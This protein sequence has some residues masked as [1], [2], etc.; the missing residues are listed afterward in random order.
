MVTTNRLKKQQIKQI[1]LGARGALDV[2]ARGRGIIINAG[3]QISYYILYQKL[4]F[5]A[6]VKDS[7]WPQ[8]T[9]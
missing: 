3:T 6:F 8:K 5:W 9:D 1:F 2:G 7:P 4:I